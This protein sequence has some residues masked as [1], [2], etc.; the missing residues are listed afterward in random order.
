MFGG[1]AFGYGGTYASVEPPSGYARGDYA[2]GRDGG[3]G[4]VARGVVAG[5]SVEADLWS[6]QTAGLTD[7]P[8]ERMAQTVEPNDAQRAILDELR[9]A[10]ATAL[11]QLKAACPTALPSTPTG[12]IEAMRQRLEAMLAAVR[13]L[14]PVLE[15]VY[16]SLND[17]Q[18]ARV[19]A[20][21][22]DHPDPPQAQGHLA[23]RLRGRAS[24]IAS[25]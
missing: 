14:R 7:W 8:I 22:P 1:Y 4:S 9:D 5:R 13:T 20:L 21:S 19:N 24:Q 11:D 17:E 23:P 6:G 3:G 15:K 25:G 10:T 12:R 2:R 16:D 18:K